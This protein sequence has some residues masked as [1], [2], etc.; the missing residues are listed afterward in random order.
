VILSLW[1]GLPQFPKICTWS[2]SP[3]SFGVDAPGT[4]C[5]AD[6]CGVCSCLYV[7]F[8]SWWGVCKLKQWDVPS[9][10]VWTPK[11]SSGRS[12]TP[13]LT[14]NYGV[15]SVCLKVILW[16]YGHQAL[17]FFLSLADVIHRW[18]WAR[19]ILLMSKRMQVDLVT[20]SAIFLCHWY[21]VRLCLECLESSGQ[22]ILFHYV[23]WT[24]DLQRWH[25]GQRSPV[26]RTIQRSEGQSGDRWK[27]PCRLVSFATSPMAKDIACP[28]PRLNMPDN[29]KSSKI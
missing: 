5:V 12:Q 17:R 23:L 24:L 2:T 28:H 29:L 16:R 26:Q 19:S 1:Q 3:E 13:S 10:Y 21:I 27:R 14:C 8:S 15:Q 6:W 11:Q 25:L 7:S 20:C 22:S 4:K 9:C 18:A